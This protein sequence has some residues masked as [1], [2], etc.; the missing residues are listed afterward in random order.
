MRNLSSSGN[1]LVVALSACDGDDTQGL[2]VP[3]A[4][5]ERNTHEDASSLGP[6]FFHFKEISELESEGVDLIKLT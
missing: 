3:R 1:E 5:V 2:L 6:F 4:R